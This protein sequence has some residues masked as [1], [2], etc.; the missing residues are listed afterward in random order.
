MQP[1]IFRMSRDGEP[2]KRGLRSAGSNEQPAIIQ[3]PDCLTNQSFQRE[4]E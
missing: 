3:A 1:A 4:Q 2:E